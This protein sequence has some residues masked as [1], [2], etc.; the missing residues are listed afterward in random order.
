MKILMILFTVL[1]AGC[2]TTPPGLSGKTKYSMKFNDTVSEIKDDTG[3]VVAPGQTTEFV[4]DIEAA[5]GVDITGLASLEYIVNPDTGEVVIRVASEAD[6]DTTA[7][8]QALVQAHQTTVEAYKSLTPIITDMVLKSIVPISPGSGPGGAIEP[9]TPR[10]LDTGRLLAGLQS[11][12]I[13]LT[14]DQANALA[15]LLG[16]EPIR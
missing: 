9:P 5:G 6:A 2:L 11:I 4:T 1:L 12:G 10:K 14:V 7:Q 15:E 16:M 8:A 13:H 3:A